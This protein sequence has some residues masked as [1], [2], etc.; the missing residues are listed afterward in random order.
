MRSLALPVALVTLPLLVLTARIGRAQHPFPIDLKGYDGDGHVVTI[1]PT[2]NANI[3]YSPKAT[4]SGCHDYDTIALSYHVQQGRTV[5]DD[6][7][8]HSHDRPDFVLSP[9]MFGGW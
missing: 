4:C 8:G 9:G 1:T 2:E 3:P 6:A 5:I 7:Y